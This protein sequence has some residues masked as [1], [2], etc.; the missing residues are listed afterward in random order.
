[1]SSSRSSWSDIALPSSW[2]AWRSSESTSSRSARSRCVAARADLLEDQVVGRLERLPQGAALRDSARPEQGELRHPLGVGR[3]G[4]AALKGV[5]QPP[6]RG[7]RPCTPKTVR[8][9]TSSVIACIVGHAD[10][11][12]AGGPALDLARRDLG[13]RLLVAA[14]AR[15]VERRQHQLALRHVGVLVEQQHRVA[16]EHRQQHHVRLAGMQQP[17]VAREDLLDRVRIGNEDPRALVG[18][19]QREHVAVAA[20][21]V[22]QHRR[23]PGDPAS[24]LKRARRARARRRERDGVSTVQRLSAHR[25][26]SRHRLGPLSMLLFRRASG[27]PAARGRPRPRRTPR[28]PPRR[29]AAGRRRG[30]APG[31]RPPRR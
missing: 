10:E 13:H 29:A 27:R 19:L 4:K 18:D 31:P 30:P 2:R 21:A 11:R 9:I 7:R 1:M 12:L 14:H 6:Q 16:A 25:T 24:G 15:A 23:R 22:L 3:P 5:A 17:R 20:R 28:S 26:T 8:M